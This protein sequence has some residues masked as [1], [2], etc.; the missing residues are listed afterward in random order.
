[1]HQGSKV[2]QRTEKNETGQQ[3]IRDQWGSQEKFP[4]RRKGWVRTHR[5]STFPTGTCAILR[6]KESS[7]HT[8]TRPPD[9]FRDLPRVSAEYHSRPQGRHRPHTP[10]QPRASDHN[11]NR[12]SHSAG[13]AVTLLHSSLPNKALLLLPVQQPLYCLNSV[14]GH[15]SVFPWTKSRKWTGQFL[16]T[17]L[18]LARWDLPPRACSTAVPLLP[19]LCRGTQPCV[20]SE[21]TP[22]VHGVTP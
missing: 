9:H 15:C 18:L 11:T 13:G 2:R 14:S 10:Q 1:M 8:T 7:L 22:T 3:P 21:N 19:E 6:M 17:P 16:P 5:R 20:P 12:G 4:N